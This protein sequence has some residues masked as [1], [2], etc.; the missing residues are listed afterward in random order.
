MALN[1]EDSDQYTLPFH[2]PSGDYNV[3]VYDIE[4]NG[5]ILSGVAYPAYTRNGFTVSGAQ[6][7]SELLLWSKIMQT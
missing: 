4:P 3:S 5:T 6:D 2:L 1:R 7:Q